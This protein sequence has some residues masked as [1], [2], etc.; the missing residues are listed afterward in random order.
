MHTR[1]PAQAGCFLV[2]HSGSFRLVQ[3]GCGYL[4]VTPAMRT[5]VHHEYG[6]PLLFN[7][8]QKRRRDRLWYLPEC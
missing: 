1:C 2:E 4:Q 7:V 3:S 6:R 5:Q 8:V